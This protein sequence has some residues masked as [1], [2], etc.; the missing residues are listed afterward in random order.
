MGYYCMSNKWVL[1]TLEIFY[2]NLQIFFL[3]TTLNDLAGLFM[4]RLTTIWLQFSWK[5]EKIHQLWKGNKLSNLLWIWLYVKYSFMK[6]YQ[7]L[8]DHISTYHPYK[9]RNTSL[10]Q[11][12][13]PWNKR[14]TFCRR[15]QTMG[16]PS[17]IKH[18]IWLLW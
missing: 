13:I 18:K 6:C 2:K 15:N 1:D 7:L 17:L 8:I 10:C 14:K 11:Y 12:P 9:Q 5:K 4:M 16:H 3:E